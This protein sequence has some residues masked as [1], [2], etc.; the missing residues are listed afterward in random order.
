[1]DNVKP[2]GTT[3]AAIQK[4]TSYFEMAPKKCLVAVIVFEG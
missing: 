3:A 4:A 1:M 2:G